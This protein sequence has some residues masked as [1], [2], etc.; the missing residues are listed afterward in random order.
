VPRR[1]RGKRFDLV[2]V[3]GPSKPLTE[4]ER[5]EARDLLARAQ[6]EGRFGSSD[7]YE[8]RLERLANAS[9]KADLSPLLDDL[10]DLLD[11]SL[12]AGLL[13]VIRAAHARGHLSAEQFDQRTDRSLGALRATQARELV[14]DL[15]YG[16]ERQVNAPRLQVLVVRV[17]PPV[18]AGV[19]S[20]AAVLAAPVA[21]GTGVAHWV[22]LALGAGVFGTACA[23]GVALA[24][25]L[26]APAGWRFGARE[27]GVPPGR[28]GTRCEGTGADEPEP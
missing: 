10:D 22:P 2:P 26:R 20:G 21:L 1:R 27:A 19:C 15:G 24:W 23:S 11:D 18:L 3:T 9:T 7:V 28:R 13:A 6:G 4:S 12:R 8:Q 25:R 14:A 17:I 16:I 5:R